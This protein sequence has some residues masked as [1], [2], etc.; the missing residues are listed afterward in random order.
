MFKAVIFDLDE[1][2]FNY[3]RPQQKALEY[4]SKKYFNDIDF[5]ERYN[6]VKNIVQNRKSGHDKYFYFKELVELVDIS[7]KYE[8]LLNINK[9]YNKIFKNEISLINDIVPFLNF[10]KEIL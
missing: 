6:K 5:F 1:T 3:E 4:I 8:T 2:V 9:D 10:L 7:N